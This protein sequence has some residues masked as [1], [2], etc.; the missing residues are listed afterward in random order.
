MEESELATLQRHRDRLLAQKTILL[1]ARGEFDQPEMGV[2]PL[3]GMGTTC[4]FI[5]AVC[6]RMCVR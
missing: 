5:Q 1:T 2:T 4:S 6:R 3:S